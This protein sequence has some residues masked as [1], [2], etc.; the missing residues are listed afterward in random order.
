[1]ISTMP[2][3]PSERVRIDLVP[4]LEDQ[5]YSNEQIAQRRAWVEEKTGVALP[6]IGAF[7]IASGS[8]RGNVENPIGAAQVPLG[9]AGPLRVRGEHADGTFYVPLATTEGALVRSY[10]RGMVTL[11]H[12]GGAEARVYEDENRVSPSFLCADVAA[13]RALALWI[14]AHVDEIRGRAEATTRHGRLLRLACHPAGRQLIVDFSYSTGDASGM[15][16]IVAATDAA[17]RWIR[18][19]APASIGA[20]HL[21]FSGAESEKRPSPSLLRGGKGKRVTAGAW[22]PEKVLK[23]VLRVSASDLVRLWQR[24]AVGHVIGGVAGYNGQV[25]NGLAAIFIA[26]GQDVANLANA[27]V[28]I[29]T[30]EEV[31]DGALYASV[32]LPSLT[33]ATI[34][35]GTQV[36]TASECLA[37]LGCSGAGRARAFAEIVAATVLAGELS[38]GAAIAAGEMAQAHEELGRNR[39]A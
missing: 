37:L 2:D 13:A 23:M 14:Q 1:M 8:M 17:C 28:A 38:F 5:G 20:T 12:A 33:V 25:A 34:G 15:N 26:C 36:A 10:E 21:I 7:S 18:E 6:G 24:T 31:A 32:T 35:G 4:R 11:T 27:A 3:S 22:I 39:P 29:S 16:M 30:F 9:L 19:A